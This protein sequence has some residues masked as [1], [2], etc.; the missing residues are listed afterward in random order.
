MESLSSVFLSYS[1]SNL[2]AELS[3]KLRNVDVF[4]DTIMFETSGVVIFEKLN[5]DYTLGEISSN[6]NKSNFISLALPIELN[7]NR[8]LSLG[9]LS[10]YDVAKTGETWFFPEEKKIIISVA[11]LSSGIFHPELYSLDLNTHKLIK[12]F[13]VLPVDV[14]EF[15][16]LQGTQSIIDRPVISYNYNTKEYVY[17]TIIKNVSGD[18]TLVEVY[19]ENLPT[20]SLREMIVYNILH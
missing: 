20:C 17:S 14:L 11:W 12:T 5:Y 7:L 2:Y 15:E 16:G 1:N 19:I 3:T 13:P 4:Y 8:E 18:N 9:S 10:G 6:T